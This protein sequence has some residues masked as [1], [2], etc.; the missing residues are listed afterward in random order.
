MKSI[1][2]PQGEEF[3]RQMQEKDSAQNPLEKESTSSKEKFLIC[4]FATKHT[5][6]AAT[7]YDVCMY[8]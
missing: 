8:L 6:V 7:S 1:T 2:F 4:F 3:K 5:F